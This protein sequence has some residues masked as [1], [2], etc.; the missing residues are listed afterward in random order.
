MTVENEQLSFDGATM[1]RKIVQ[2]SDLIRPMIVK[3][4]L[5]QVRSVK[6][7]SN[8]IVWSWSMDANQ[9]SITWDDRSIGSCIPV[10]Q[11][12]NKWQ[13]NFDRRPI[14]ERR[15]FN[16]DRPMIVL[17]G[18]LD[19]DRQTIITKG[20]MDFDLWIPNSRRPWTKECVMYRIPIDHR[21][22]Q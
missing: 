22:Y 3:L 9:S 16:Y 7:E 14:V 19:L 15:S 5:R 10:A 11:R 1:E 4:W 20:L 17:K 21:P 2:C 13:I 6:V 18:L 8:G 12:W